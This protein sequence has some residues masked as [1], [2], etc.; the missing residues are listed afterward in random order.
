MTSATPIDDNPSSVPSTDAETDAAV[1]LEASTQ[2]LARGEHD[3]GLADARAAL[4]V[5]DSDGDRAKALS[6]VSLHACRLGD[7]ILA[8]EAG[9]DALDAWNGTDP[10]AESGALCTLS[11][12]CAEIGAYGESVTLATR[13]FDLAQTTGSLSRMAK[14]LNAVGTA[15]YRIGDHALGRSCLLR[16]LAHAEEQNDFDAILAAFNNLCAGA[17][18]A[19]HDHSEAGLA[20]D[21]AAAAAEAVT[22]ARRAVAQAESLGDAYRLAAVTA[23]LGEALGLSGDVD[24]GL[25]ALNE[26]ESIA[27]QRGFVALAMHVR[28]IIGEMLVRAGLSDAAAEH[29]RAT[30]EQMPADETALNRSRVHAALHR[31]LKGLG[32]FEESL[33]HCEAALALERRRTA[34]QTRSLAALAVSRSDVQMAQLE[35]EH[36]R[37]QNVQL[38]RRARELEEHALHDPLTGLGNRRLL[39]RVVQPLAANA[40]VSMAVLDIDHFKQINDRFGHA[41]G[42]AVLRELAAILQRC[43]RET[44]TAVRLGGE[45]FGL[46]LMPA[47]LDVARA[48]C[49]RVRA[50]IEAADWEPIATGL[51]VHASLGVA[52]WLGESDRTLKRADDA[53]Y[54]AKRSGRN[55]V[56]VA[57]LE[58]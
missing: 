12:V 9:H 55:Q 49:E 23:N 36:A 38:E 17:L 18:V 46:V 20:D 58:G 30:L 7:L 24:T 31:A 2:A 35:H 26:A 29:L 32:R 4:A 54:S 34:E 19:H 57:L 27:S 41:I 5:A 47:A 42:D 43:L 52:P 37:L 1:L 3:R 40:P 45:E 51:R 15:R 39:D 25:V 33:S 53:L 13:A 11:M 10:L 21:A 16:A 8:Y 14:A 48:V 28:T 22:Y 50:T 6:L 44:D 56:C